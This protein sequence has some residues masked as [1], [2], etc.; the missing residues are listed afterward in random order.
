MVSK[1]HSCW[2]D[3][4]QE[5]VLV[6]LEKPKASF[7][8]VLNI[9]TFCYGVICNIW[10]LRDRKKTEIKGTNPLYQITD[11]PIDLN[12]YLDHLKL[13]SKN[14]FEKNLQDDVI[15]ELNKMLRS[16]NKKT[17]EYANMLYDLC[18]GKNRLQISK[19]LGINYKIV[20]Q[21][22]E[23]AID[24]IKKNMTGKP[25]KQEI[26]VKLRSEKV[27][28]SY[29]GKTQTFYVN[30]EPSEKVKELINKAGYKIEKK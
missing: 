4:Y 13:G 24:L 7:K 20:Y 15:E 2:E 14:V 16:D 8:E 6:I 23:K 30:T 21:S 22:I 17:R 11:R 19:E 12:D 9:D 1:N 5:F 10:Y 28:A 18:L 26:S 27:Q 3:L 29:S 25:T